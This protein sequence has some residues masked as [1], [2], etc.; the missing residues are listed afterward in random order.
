[1]LGLGGPRSHS[2]VWGWFLCPLVDRA[3][4]RV[5]L[6]SEVLKSAYLLVGGAVSPPC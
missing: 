2:V 6:G 5:A 3:M 4:Y 1:M